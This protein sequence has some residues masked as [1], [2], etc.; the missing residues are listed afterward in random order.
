[1]SAPVPANFQ[2]ELPA[3][4]LTRKKGIPRMIRTVAEGVRL[5]DRSLPP[6]LRALPRWTFARAL[7][8]EAERTKKKRDIACAVRQLKQALS[9]E[10][11]LDVSEAPP[12]TKPTR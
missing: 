12:S 11:W 6:E 1:M 10:G 4:V 3:A 9:N 5:I 8:M 7:L 2:V